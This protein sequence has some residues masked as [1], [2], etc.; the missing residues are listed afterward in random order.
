M[1][2][3]DVKLMEKEKKAI[4]IGNVEALINLEEK[5]VD[6]AYENINLKKEILNIMRNLS[7]EE[8]LKLIK[9]IWPELEAS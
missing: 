9:R 4:I 7:L 5:L 6:A 3:K 2:F 8:C 1:V